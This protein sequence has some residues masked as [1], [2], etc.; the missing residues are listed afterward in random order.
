MLVLNNYNLEQLEVATGKSS[1][2][3]QTADEA[4]YFAPARNFASTGVWKDNFEGLS[5]YFQRP[6]GYGF[7]F[8]LCEKMMGENALLLLKGIQILLSGTAFFLFGKILEQLKLGDKWIYLFTSIFAILPCFT[9]FV[10]Y[11]LTESLIP[12]MLLFTVFLSFKWK[13]IESPLAKT[14]LLLLLGCFVLVRPQMMLF[15][16][17]L[18]ITILKP[19]KR[20]S[21]LYLAILT[22]PW[23]LWSVR[24]YNIKGDFVSVHP[25][26]DNTNATV[27]RAPHQKLT[28]V[29][30]YWEHKPEK[31]HEVVGL[32]KRDTL[33]SSRISAFETLPVHIKVKFKYKVLKAFDAFQQAQLAVKMNKEFDGELLKEESVAL[34]LISDLEKVLRINNSA[35]RNLIVPIKSLGD[36]IQK[37]Y[38]NHFVFQST[39]RDYFVVKLLKLICVSFTILGL[40]ALILN[41]FINSNSQLKL[42]NISVLLYLFYLGFIQVLNEDRYFFILLPILFLN[43]VVQIHHHLRF[44]F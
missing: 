20:S 32:L 15:L 23:V 21:F 8:Y 9:G 33:M 29:F 39:W 44:K 19:L 10:Y 3:I 13:S 34:V 27:F 36:L 12:F 22:L 7:L 5:S 35:D 30:K 24:N 41:F 28:E 16:L 2:L 1:V 42:F 18:S 31:L 40:I 25:I 17:P 14:V 43:L 37:S 4:S 38:L 26:Y 11:S 6:P